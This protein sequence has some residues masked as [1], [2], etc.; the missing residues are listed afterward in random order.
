MAS[1]KESR[2]TDSKPIEPKKELKAFQ[3]FI[4]GVKHIVYAQNLE[5][6]NKKFKK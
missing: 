1:K 5:E 2:A 4:D 6:A 3:R